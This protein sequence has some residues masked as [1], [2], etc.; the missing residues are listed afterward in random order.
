MGRAEVTNRQKLR[1]VGLLPLLSLV[2]TRLRWSSCRFCHLVGLMLVGSPASGKSKGGRPRGQ[3]PGQREGG[4]DGRACWNSLAGQCV[5][6][7]SRGCDSVEPRCCVRWNPLAGRESVRSV[8]VTLCVGS[9]WMNVSAR[10]LRYRPDRSRLGWCWNLLDVCECPSR[11]PDLRRAVRRDALERN[12][13][14]RGVGTCWK[15]RVGFR[16]SDAGS[17]T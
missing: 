9:R 2:Q 4:S 6:G 13:R 8:R 16:A 5:R 14:D 11:V 7:A 10:V 1:V 17:R 15:N 3:S 12:R